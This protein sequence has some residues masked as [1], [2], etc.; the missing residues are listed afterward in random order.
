[1]PK[2]VNKCHFFNS[3]FIKIAC[4]V[5]EVWIITQATM[6]IFSYFLWVT[7]GYSADK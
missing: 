1:M 2:N 5:L 6:N 4:Y 3:R 7:E